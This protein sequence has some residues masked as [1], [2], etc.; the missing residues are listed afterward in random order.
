MN[1]PRS[2]SRERS[3]SYFVRHGLLLL[4]AMATLVALVGIVRSTF[5]DTTTVTVVMDDIGGGIAPG[6]D[7]KM[8]GLAVGR[9]AS[10]GGDPAEVRLDLE[11]EDR[12]LDRIPGDVEARVL[13]ASVFGTS[14]VELVSPSKGASTDVLRSGETIR[15]DTSQPTLEL[16]RALDSIDQ[17]VTAL[18]PADLSVVLHAMAGSL[19]GRGKD[20]HQTLGKLDHLLSVVNPRIPLLRDDLS[21]LLINLRTVKAAAPDLLDTLAATAEVS[22][23]LV[24]HRDQLARLLEAALEL[25]DDGDGLL[26]ATEQKYIRA[27]LASADVSDAVYDNR[28]GISRQTRALDALLTKVLTVTDGGAIRID[29]RITDPTHWSYYDSGDCPRY[30]NAPGTNCGRE[31]R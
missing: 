3:E 27:I 22:H 21:L 31:S 11:L 5:T 28:S 7:V 15:Q 18:G 10:V 19:D 20:I 24:Q 16:Q 9:V 17:L 25:V 6:A 29:A 1:A 30:E 13:P 12:F 2:S 14:F 26:D 23:G 8:R 4:V